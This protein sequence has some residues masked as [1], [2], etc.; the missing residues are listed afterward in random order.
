MVT[1]RVS[2]P[3]TV[4]CPHCHTTYGPFTR[5]SMG[6]WQCSKCKRTIDVR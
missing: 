2:R 6:S 1:R 3:F 4:T 5:L